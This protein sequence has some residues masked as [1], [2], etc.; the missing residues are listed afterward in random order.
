M[1][2]PL[3]NLLPISSEGSFGALRRYDIHTGIDLYC[4]NGDE[5]Y[6]IEDGI[7]SA[8]VDFTG[9]CAGSPWWND[10][11]AVFV[12]GMSGAVLYGEIEPLIKVG[13]KIQAGDLIGKVIQVLKKDKGKPLCML[14][15]ECYTKG[16]TEPVWWYIGDTK[17]YNLQNPW[18]LIRNHY[19]YN[20]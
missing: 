6:S 20:K 12:E 16:T 11:K 14:H 18:F 19:E 3:K 13:D 17:P 10:T 5:V 8:I 1:K 4:E 2:K 15:L 9:P 7:I